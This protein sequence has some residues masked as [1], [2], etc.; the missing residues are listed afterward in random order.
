MSVQDEHELRAR[1]S[2]LLD[3]VEPRPA[4]VM[5]VVRRGRGIRMRRW[6]S[7]AAG[8]AIIAA[9]A[10]L[11][12]GFL[13]THRTVPAAPPHYK[14]TVTTPGGTAIGGVI[15]EGTI[16]TK[17]WRVVVNRSMGGACTPQPY[18]LTCG[19]AYSGS[20]VGPR[21]VNLGSLG[22]GGTQYE[23][24]PVGTDVS[25]VALRLSNGTV[26]SLQPVL[27]GGRRWVAVAAPLYA[28]TQA[29]SFVGQSEYQYAIPFNTNGTAG[30][31]TWLRPG[32]A[33]LPV[34]SR[35][36]GSGEFDGVPWHAAVHAG[37]WG[38][39]ATFANGNSR[40]PASGPGSL[41]SHELPQ[42][43]SACFPAT[44]PAQLLSGRIV[45][46][47]TCSPFYT[48]SGKATGASSGVAAV[49]PDVKDVVLQFAG[50]GRERM[51]AVPISGLRMLGYAI[52]ARLKLVRT[53][54][55]GVHG[56][57][58]HSASAAGW[59]C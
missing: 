34:A 35:S 27:A 33:G 31:I 54:E 41:F 3:G 18:V 4:P 37:P 42:A 8:V 7:V 39:C 5:R 53:L 16:G 30:F 10:A 11:I 20:N 24:G 14:V 51:A 58:L 25:R 9:G 49:P 21:Q 28:I 36:L 55:Y 29:V 17:R 15:G 59:G 40:L 48:S 22:A 23:L 57:L 26:L 47:L 38:Y 46:P 2:A 43:G 50:G 12:P 19:F 13:Q 52:P 56:Q 32:Q 45:A 6:I 44:N 1:L